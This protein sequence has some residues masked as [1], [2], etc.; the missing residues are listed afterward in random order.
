MIESAKLLATSIGLFKKEIQKVREEVEL[1]S[2]QGPPGPIGEQGPKGDKGDSGPMGPMG[3]IGERG[4]TGLQGPKGD[5]GE[6]GPVGERGEQ[7]LIG[8][9]GPVGPVGPKGEK[10]DK[11]L[12]GEQ[13]PQGEKGETGERGL[14]GEQGPKGPQGEPGP[15][16][17]I[18]EQGPIG[19]K[20]DKGDPGPQGKVGPKGAKGAKGDPANVTEVKKQMREF[21]KKNRQELSSIEKKLNDLINKGDYIKEFEAKFRKEVEDNI[22]GYK[23]FINGKVAQSGW[24]STSSGGG[25]VNILQ[26]DDVE[27]AKRHEVEGNA[28]L[29]FDST[30]QKFISE[31]FTTVLDRLKADLEVQYNKFVDV[32]G[33]YTYIGESDPGTSPSAAS[34]RIK[35]VYETNTEGDIEIA[36]AS[37][38]SDFDKVWDDRA[39]YNYS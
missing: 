37:G 1:K 35:R 26:M 19:P 21:I 30:K 6:P 29:I 23:N 8:E 17:L 18:G 27:F 31:S 20:G 38:T 34:W 4:L 25:S 13:G 22:Q 24:G 36:W 32:E 9:Q 10:G 16:G 3:F 7:G 15:Q 5:T 2:F 33:D 11:G 12:I 39:T 14:I 28:I